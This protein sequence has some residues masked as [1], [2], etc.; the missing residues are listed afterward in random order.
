MVE[1]VCVFDLNLSAGGFWAE[2]EL[3]GQDA[4]LSRQL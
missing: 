2:E 1:T 3:R 4:V